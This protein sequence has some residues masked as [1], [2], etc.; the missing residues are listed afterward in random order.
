MLNVVVSKNKKCYIQQYLLQQKEI[1]I[2][3][4][5]NITTLEDDN[6]HTRRR[7]H[8]NCKLHTVKPDETTTFL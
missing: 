4:L 5:N 3:R 8:I 2:T 1:N 6:K 7:E